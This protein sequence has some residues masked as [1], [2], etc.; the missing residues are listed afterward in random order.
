VV[1]AADK[2]WNRFLEERKAGIEEI[3]AIRQRVED[4]AVKKNGDSDDVETEGFQNVVTGDAVVLSKD[5]EMEVD[6]GNSNRDEL[7]VSS[8]MAEPDK[9]EDSTVIQADDDDAVEY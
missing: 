3:N 4:E 7:K 6:D 5:I 1:E 8:T 9:K 2:E